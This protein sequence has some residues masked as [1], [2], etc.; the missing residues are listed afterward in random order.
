MASFLRPPQ[1]EPQHGERLHSYVYLTR[2]LHVTRK[3]PG[4]AALREHSLCHGV[5]YVAVDPNRCHEIE[6]TRR[7][8]GRSND[9]VPAPV[10][11]A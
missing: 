6:A 9:P 2:L 8:Q 10:Y 11:L 4:F 1:G 7:V 5:R 3:L